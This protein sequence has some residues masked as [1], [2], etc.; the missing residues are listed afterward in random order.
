MLR[1]SV[2]KQGCSAQSVWLQ[3]VLLVCAVIPASHRFGND[4]ARR[5]PAGTSVVCRACATSAWAVPHWESCFKCPQQGCQPESGS[6][7][8]YSSKETGKG[9]DGY[10]EE[11]RI[12]KTWLTWK[13]PF[14]SFLLSCRETN[15][16]ASWEGEMGRVTSRHGCRWLCYGKSRQ[17]L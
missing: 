11:R 9:L 14:A 3:N 6:N 13:T 4:C 1:S 15:V 10:E 5:K 2:S 16:V 7:G 8:K 17:A 12:G